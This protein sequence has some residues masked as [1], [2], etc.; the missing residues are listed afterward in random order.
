MLD[1]E[2]DRLPERLRLAV[3]HCYVEGRSTE[4]AAKFLSVPRGTILSRL[5]KA[6]DLLA[7]RLTR[8]GVTAPITAAT[9]TAALSG[10]T[11]SASLVAAATSTVMLPVAGSAVELLSLE[12]LRMTAWKTTIAWAAAIVLT[13][14]IGTGTGIILAQGEKPDAASSAIAQ[15]SGRRR[16]SRSKTAREKDKELQRKAEMDLIAGEHSKAVEKQMLLQAKN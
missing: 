8:R 1:A 5:S 11:V 15:V 6:R 3:L 14:G 10:E 12:V 16:G 2:I 13:A 7:E 4:D 9:L